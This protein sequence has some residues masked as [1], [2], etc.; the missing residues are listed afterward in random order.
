MTISIFLVVVT[1]MD[2]LKYKNMMVMIIHASRVLILFSS[3]WIQM[4]QERY[5]LYHMQRDCK[6]HRFT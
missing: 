1:M 4:W 2:L 5:I 3:I 6:V